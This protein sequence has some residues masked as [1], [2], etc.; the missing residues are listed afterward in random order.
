MA[1][2]GLIL[3]LKPVPEISL[4]E[5]IP[6]CSLLVK[7]F[8]TICVGSAL[9]I[10]YLLS[11]SWVVVITSTAT[12]KRLSDNTK[13][14]HLASVIQSYIIQSF[15]FAVLATAHRFGTNPECNHNVFVVIFRPFS[16]LKAGRI[17]GWIVFG[18]SF[19]CYTAMTIRDYTAQ[20]LNKIGQKEGS[21][22]Q[23]EEPSSQYL[24]GGPVA[25]LRQ[26]GTPMEVGT[27]A[28]QRQVR[29]ALFT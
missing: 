5:Y 19:A 6:Q 9:I 26:M 10:L 14:L 13:V 7:L 25:L 3:G 21:R 29:A 28:P 27:Q 1:I 23:V 12:C 15:A 8:L 20:V 16:A 18:L 4:Q 24:Q 17:F 11:M 22:K 2:T